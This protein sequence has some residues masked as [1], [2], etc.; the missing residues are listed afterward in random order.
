MLN[1]TTVALV[2]LLIVLV[3]AANFRLRVAVAASI[4]AMLAFNFF[5]LPPVGTLTIAD[6]QNWVALAVF[7]AVSLVASNLSA[8]ARERAV[9]ATERLQLLEDKKAAEMARRSEELKSALL[10]SLAHDLR[11]PLT[12]IR[13][14]TTNL[15]ASWLTEDDR[16]EQSEIVLTEVDRLTRLFQNILDMA[17]IDAGAV[18]S[19]LRA[20]HP[21]EVVEAAR[22]SVQ[23]ALR[24][25]HVVTAVEGDRVVS[26]DPRL[27]A[28]ALSHLLENAAQYSPPGS[29]IWIRAT[30][31]D[32][33]LS[34]EVRDSGPGIPLRDMPRLFERFYRGDHSG[35]HTTGTGMG[36]PIARGL[37][38]AERGTVS[39]A[40]ADEGGAVFTITVPANAPDERRAAS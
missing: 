37:L 7:L 2:L 18:Q 3:I 33:A 11:T 1:T 39:A 6:P 26:V 34:I 14:A 25:H 16:K 15:Q 21:L 35:R 5:F 40:N 22:D 19:S 10:A 9:L 17:R 20:V 38:A 30:V 31:S 8:K 23:H 13:V 27:T 12:A 32:T 36:L 29:T 28:A 24:D 4:A